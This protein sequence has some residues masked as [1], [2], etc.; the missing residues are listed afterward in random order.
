MTAEQHGLTPTSPIS[1]AVSHLEKRLREV[2]L[3][4][5]SFHLSVGEPKRI[6]S[7]ELRHCQSGNHT[8][9]VANRFGQGLDNH[10]LSKL[11]GPILFTVDMNLQLHSSVFMG[12]KPPGL[13]ALEN[14][15][16]SLAAPTKVAP[17]VP[18]SSRFP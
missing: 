2:F 8:V 16:S 17:N 9:R 6:S 5:L 10:N 7:L 1:E 3:C 11:W 14:R 4:F 13:A 15:R 12:G 18:N